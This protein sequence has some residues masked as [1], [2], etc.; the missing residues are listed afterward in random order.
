MISKIDSMLD[1]KLHK[2][3]SKF[4]SIISFLRSSSNIFN[5]ILS[6]PSSTRNVAFPDC[7]CGI[8]VS[9]SAIPCIVCHVEI[10]AWRPQEKTFHAWW[11]ILLPATCSETSTAAAGGGGGVKIYACLLCHPENAMANSFQMWGEVWRMV[12]VGFKGCV[13]GLSSAHY[14]NSLS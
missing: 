4:Q 7:Y 13:F 8:N 12:M 14:T 3:L 5:N 2:S 6:D 11:G 10:L 9:V 1:L